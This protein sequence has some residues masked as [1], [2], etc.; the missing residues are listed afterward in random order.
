VRRLLPW[1]IV[2][3]GGAAQGFSLAWPWGLPDPTDPVSFAVYAA[4]LPWLDA[5]MT[6]AWPT[7]GQPLPWLQ[8]LAIGGLV[9]LLRRATSVQAA[10]LQGWL[11]ATAWLAATFWWLVV[12]MH[13]YGDLPLPLALAAVVALAAFLGLYYGAI[14]M[15]FKALPL[16][17]IAFS[18][19]LFAGLWTLA[20]LAR[21]VLFTGFPWGAVGYV[22][23]NTLGWAAPWVGVYGMGALAVGLSAGL[24]LSAW[25]GRRS[26]LAWGAVFV[27]L[28][29]LGPGLAANLPDL[30][31][32][33]GMLAVRLLQG[34]I[35]QDEKFEPGKGVERALAWYGDGL[36]AESTVAADTLP[37]LVIAPE[38]AVPLLPQQAGP[39][40]WVPLLHALADGH[41]AVLTGLPL[42]SFEQGYANAA[43]G[44]TPK[45]AAEALA[46]L[47]GGS[48]IASMEGMDAGF[49]R[50]E[51]HHLVPFGEFIPLGDFNRGALGQPGFEWAGQ[52]VAP[53]ICYEDLFG[54][55]LARTF[56]NPDTAPTVLANISNLAWFGNT[57]AMDQHLN[58][59]RL[60]AMELGRPMVRATNTGATVTINHLGEVTH[61]W[62]RLTTGELV[63]QVQG[64]EGLTPYARWASRWGLWPVELLAGLVVVLAWLS[65]RGNRGPWRRGP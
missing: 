17:G 19:A 12:S 41:H 29:W 18:A 25:S 1:L 37:E 30:T 55:E 7:A 61:A 40:F 42:G 2:A 16:D 59:S 10:G 5:A 31:R 15:L 51:K 32:P 34:N 52:R 47:R 11:F 23:V 45:A 38:T 60:R 13:T 36:A 65:A 64:R 58:I 3:L 39:E 43:W 6:Y 54:D 35:A 56:A 46:V 4:H 21:T 49:Y 9:V 48:A 26:V 50:Y 63:A 57:V 20:E 14:C 24:A 44:I 27:L 33:H 62:P 22:H 53:N 8:V 28:A